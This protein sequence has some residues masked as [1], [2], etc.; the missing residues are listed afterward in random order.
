MKEIVEIIE[1]LTTKKIKIAHDFSSGFY[2]IFKE[3]K[4]PILSKVFHKIYTE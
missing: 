2:E 4:I 1:S 3:D